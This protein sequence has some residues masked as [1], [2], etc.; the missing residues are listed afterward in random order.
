MIPKNKIIHLSK[1]FASSP[2]YEQ[3]GRGIDS[4]LGKSFI[5]FWGFGL[6]MFA[7]MGMMGF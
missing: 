4:G 3:C 1:Y 5:I 2:I 7:I 6:E